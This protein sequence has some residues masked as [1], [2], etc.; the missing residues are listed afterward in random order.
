MAP[1]GDAAW[2]RGAVQQP[3]FGTPD[4][5]PVP[6]PAPGSLIG[7]APVMMR[8]GILASHGALVLAAVVGELVAGSDVMLT[9]V[10]AGLTVSVLLIAGQYLQMLLV[11]RADLLGMAGTLAGFGMRV[12]ALGAALAIW[13]AVADHYPVI[14]PWGVVAGA[15]AVTL[16]WLAGVLATYRRLRIPVFDEPAVTGPGGGVQRH[17][18]RDDPAL[19]PC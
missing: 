9:T 2:Y 18:D 4:P 5:T 19:P 6:A 11:R 14:R 10:L 13:L 15:T 7:Q 8:G 12:A 16:G 1:G 17:D 3:T